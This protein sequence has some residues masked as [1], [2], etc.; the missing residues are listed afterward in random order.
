METLNLT[1][2]VSRNI[3]IH[4]MRWVKKKSIAYERYAGVRE[5]QR[6]LECHKILNES[7]IVM[8]NVVKVKKIVHMNIVWAEK[9]KR[10]CRRRLF[11]KIEKKKSVF[12]ISHSLSALK[13][14][15]HRIVVLINEKI[16]LVLAC[17]YRVGMCFDDIR[18]KSALLKKYIS[19]A[20]IVTNAFCN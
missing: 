3:E 7:V 13:Y 4:F 1:A 20:T 19:G 8:E 11:L 9:K 12:Y 17:V 2:F 10:I 15:L 6:M 14:L 5:T 16:P 18:Q